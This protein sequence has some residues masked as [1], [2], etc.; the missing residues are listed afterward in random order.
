L[1][2]KTTHLDADGVQEGGVVVVLHDGLHATGLHLVESGSKLG[3]VGKSL[4]LGRG[5]L[6]VLHH[7]GK[8]HNLTETSQ[9]HGVLGGVLNRLL[10][11]L[12][13]SG[14]GLQPLLNLGPIGIGDGGGAA[15]ADLGAIGKHHSLV[16]HCGRVVV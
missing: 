2:G 4:E 3:V 13:L 7:L 9:L 11:V 14:V 10:H 16:G 15:Q 12:G 1:G 5:V 6:V 8:S